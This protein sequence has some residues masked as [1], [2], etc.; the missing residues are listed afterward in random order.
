MIQHV[1]NQLLANYIW[2]YHTYLLRV[3]SLYTKNEGEDSSLIGTAV[4]RKY[5][6]SSIF[7]FTSNRT[8][9]C[10]HTITLKIFAFIYKVQAELPLS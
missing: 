8:K 9:L 10:S 5:R 7:S 4:D 1:F 2:Q 6:E 3:C